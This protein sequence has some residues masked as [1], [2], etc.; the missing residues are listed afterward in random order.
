MAPLV[1]PDQRRLRRSS[2]HETTEQVYLPDHLVIEQL[3]SAMRE[4]GIDIDELIVADG[5]LHRYHV[6]GDRGRSRN[7]WAVLHIDEHPAAQFGC[8]KRWG[9]EKFTWTMKGTRPLTADER[10]EIKA[11]AAARA[12]QRQ[13]ETEINHQHAA[14]RARAIYDAAEPVTEHP[15]LTL[16]GVPSSAK[17]RVGNWHYIDEETGE[18][19]LVSDRALLVPMMD[20]ALRIHSLQAIFDD[21]EGGFRKQYLRHGAKEGK[22]VSIGKPRDNVILI[23]E[24]LATGLSLWKCCNHAVIV[25]FDAGNLIHVARE[26]RR[27]LPDATI[28]LCADNDAWSHTPIDNPGTH[29]AHIAAAAVNGLVVHP[30]FVNTDSKPTDFNDLHQLEGEDAVRGY[31]ERALV[32]LSDARGSV[33][34]DQEIPVDAHQEES[35]S[36]APTSEASTADASPISLEDFYAYMPSHSYIYTP[37]REMWPASSVKSRLPTVKEA[38]G[39]PISAAAWLDQHRP[40]E[41]MTW[42]PG[43][44]MVIPD[45]LVSDG[46]WIERPGVSTFNLYRPPLKQGGDPAF[47]SRWIDHIHLVY[48]D[49][50]E[51]IL[52]WLAHRIQRPAEKVNHALVLGGNQGIGKDTLLEPIKHGVGPWNFTEVSP[53]HLLGRF[54]GFVKSVILRINEARDLGDVDRYAFYDHMKIYSASPPDVLR[55]DEKNLREHAVFN[56]CGVIISSNHKSDGIYLPADD[57]RH[58]VAWSTLSKDDF[59]ADYWQDL[60]RWYQTGGIGHVAAYLA[61]MDLSGFDPKAPPPKTMAWHEIV[62]ANRAPE[63]AELADVLDALGNRPAL[64]ITDI[65][66][67]TTNDSFKEWLGDRRNSRQIPHRLEAAGYVR[68]RNDGD[69]HDG[70]W[71]VASKRQ[72][73]YA[74]TELSIRDRIAAAHKLCR[75]DRWTN[76]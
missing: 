44:P 60:W 38:Q 30:E 6:E 47:V 16:K 4:H 31:I 39:K 57:R 50:V 17:L 3:T 58:Y 11:T 62:D 37:T 5:R 68:V 53:T 21:G 22:L 7:A 49:D 13:A 72:A 43:S 52:Y 75:G 56:V 8:Y 40:V 14:E 28:L 70:H 9:S 35:A 65:I 45:K 26:A 48:P 24:G 54:N 55:C 63:D 67:Y 41:Q 23:A 34:A 2:L 19:I 25:A 10:R 76:E 73:I 42:H 51:H 64:T 29:Y 46:G 71:K 20:A 1:S 27:V 61:Q 33:P 12:A 59:T 32:P 18:E 74:R 69:K 66:S 36:I 15:Y